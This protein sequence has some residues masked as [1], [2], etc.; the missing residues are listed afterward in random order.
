MSLLKKL[1]Q[2]PVPRIGISSYHQA[3]MEKI[4]CRSRTG[5]YVNPKATLNVAEPRW[6]NPGSGWLLLRIS[7]PR[8][9]CNRIS[10][11]K[12]KFFKLLYSISFS[13]ELIKPHF[14]SWALDTFFSIRYP[15]F[16]Y[17]NASI[18]YRY[19]DT[20]LKFVVRYS[21]FDI[22]TFFNTSPSKQDK[23]ATNHVY[24]KCINLQN[25]V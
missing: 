18:R 15:I 4:S 25:T 14:Q 24:G 22:D 21:I 16:R 7:D 20:F 11:P 6:L 12:G 23:T 10:T 8:S 3:L 13:N 5:I 19:S 17:F 1:I 2:I 9:Q